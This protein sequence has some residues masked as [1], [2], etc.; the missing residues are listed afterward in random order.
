MR[1]TMMAPLVALI[2]LG[3]IGFDV[4]AASSF[5]NSAFQTPWQKGEAITPNFW[6]PLAAA[7]DGQQEPYK[8]APGGQ[9]LVQYFDKGRMEL[10][11][12]LTI[13]PT[14]PVTSG[15]L[16]TDLVKGQV[17][18][19]DT[20]FEPKPSPAVPI[21]GDVDN[22][23]PTYAGI[24]SKGA[25]LFAPATS[26]P[27]SFVTLS[28]AADGTVTDDGGFAGISMSPATSS[29]DAT[30][31]HNVLGVFAGY[32]DRV[33]LS[34]IGFAIS[35]PFRANVKVA[36]NATTVLVQVFERRVLTYT[37]TNPDPFKVE[38]GNIGQHYYLWLY[39][40]ASAAPVPATPAPPTAT[41]ST[42]PTFP[43][44]TFTNVST[45]VNP[46]GAALVVVK[47]AP[48]ASCLITVTYKS[49]PIKMP[50]LVPKMADA[51]GVVTWA[52]LVGTTTET[53]SWPIDVTCSANG[54]TS[55]QRTFFA[56][57]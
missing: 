41:A 7:K 13:P 44:V 25:S 21:A 16:A 50:G 30:T 40:T 24:A 11:V 57:G 27:G 36:G 17:Q 1:R 37:A 35:E 18:I 9:R 34:T 39:G 48:N 19:G 33:G 26:K 53:G 14:N 47:T 32:R 29:F 49:G 42:T 28:A 38:M 23:G 22:P 10:T 31:Q 8:E 3:L 55:G 52:W 2:T 5:A 15:L 54:Q 56:V 43:G 12:A 6:G 4:D 46:G 45:P 20:A 51:T